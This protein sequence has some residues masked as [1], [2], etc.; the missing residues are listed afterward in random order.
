MVEQKKIGYF[1]GTR[2]IKYHD[3]RIELCKKYV[4]LLKKRREK[5]L[6]NTRDPD[7]HRFEH[8]N[9]RKRNRT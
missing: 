8:K 1:Y 9:T 6:K 2:V 7:I 5:Y 4:K 3:F